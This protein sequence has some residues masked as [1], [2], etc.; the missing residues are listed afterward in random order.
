[1][2]SKPTATNVFDNIEADVKQLK[3]YWNDGNTSAFK[4]KHKEIVQI[5]TDSRD[6]LKSQLWC[7][8]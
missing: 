3:Q 7:N 1:M 2:Q 8:L 6:I 5:L 4:K